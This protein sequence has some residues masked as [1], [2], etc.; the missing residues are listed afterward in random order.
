MTAHDAE[1]DPVPPA[2]LEDF[3][4]DH[5]QPV[6]SKTYQPPRGVKKLKPPVRFTRSTAKQLRE[7]GVL[8]VELRWHRVRRWVSLLPGYWFV[9]AR[10]SATASR[11]DDVVGLASRPSGREDVAARPVPGLTVG[12]G[13]A[14]QN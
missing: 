13:S 12:G 9:H 11:P 1:A 6:V 7:R 8:E 5:A 4:S 2:V 3:G 10:R 14:G